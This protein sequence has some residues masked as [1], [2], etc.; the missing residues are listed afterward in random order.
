MYG[1]VWTSGAFFGRLGGT[2]MAAKMLQGNAELNQF[3]SFSFFFVM[4]FRWS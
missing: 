3:S 2:Q 4:G 1:Q